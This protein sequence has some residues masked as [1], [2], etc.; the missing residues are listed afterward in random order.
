M[1]TEH[2]RY[3]L[4]TAQY[5]SIG[6]AAKCLHLKQQYLSTVIKSLE[7]QFGTLLFERSP[8]GITLTE[9]GRYLWEKVD[10]LIR[11]SDELMLDYLYPS[12]S[13][14]RTLHDTIHIYTPPLIS[15]ANLSAIL[16]EYQTQFPNVTVTIKEKSRLDM[17][18]CV[19][20]D[21]HAI[22]L[23]GVGEYT[24][25]AAFLEAIPEDIQALPQRTIEVVAITSTDNPS[26]RNRSS[27]TIEE[28]LKEPLIAYSPLGPD[29]SI[30]YSLL[31]MHSKPDI[32]CTVENTALFLHLMQ[33]NDYYTIG[34]VETAQAYHL[35]AIP[36]KPSFNI[37]SFMLFPKSS[38][39]SFA[40][41]SLLNLFISRS[42]SNTPLLK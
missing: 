16:A 24:D 18:R 27:I 23:T 22:C 14:T 10:S 37:S 4:L 34:T 31:S 39:S 19:L 6:K 29:S 17:T 20:E 42:Y 33:Q 32:K 15:I 9:D 3:F 8:K 7:N 25:P 2:L 13:A 30:V 41:K 35:K 38:L 26:A 1:N 12:K 5:S 21:P 11:Q 36:L 40:F 28:L